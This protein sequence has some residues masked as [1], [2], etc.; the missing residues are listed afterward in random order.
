MAG[1]L[2]DAWAEAVTPWV[3]RDLPGDQ[4]HLLLATHLT[5]AA[6]TEPGS[7]ADADRRPTTQ[8]GQPERHS[9]VAAVHGA[10]IVTPSPTTTT[11]DADDDVDDG[12]SDDETAFGYSNGTEL[13]STG[14]SAGVGTIVLGLALLMSGGGLLL[15][16]RRRLGGPRHRG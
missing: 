9:A 15:S 10:P 2:P 11:S 13:A 4:G 3:C 7:L 1:L 5:L 12:D 16:R 6:G 8:V 14:S